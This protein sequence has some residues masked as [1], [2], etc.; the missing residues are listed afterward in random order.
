MHTES[1]ALGHFQSAGDWPVNLVIRLTPVRRTASSIS[2]PTE[3][4]EQFLVCDRCHNSEEVVVAMFE[5]LPVKKQW[6]LCGPC[7]RQL[8]VGFVKV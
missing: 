2:S 8:P 4:D 5:I 6:A 3:D 7:S 1:R